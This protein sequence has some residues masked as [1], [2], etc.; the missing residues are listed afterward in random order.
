MHWN[1]NSIDKETQPIEELELFIKS[2]NIHIAS[3]NE[4]KLAESDEINIS[5]YKIIR[6]DR[7]NNGGGV[8][9]IINN[10]IE[11]EQIFDLEKYLN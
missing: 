7:N 10:Q 3:I 1:A 6:K 8:A 9:I 2:N 4:T 11:N 5:N